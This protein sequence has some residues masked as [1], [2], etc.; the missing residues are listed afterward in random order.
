MRQKWRVEE[1]R[2][3]GPSYPLKERRW[4]RNPG[5]QRNR[6]SKLSGRSAVPRGGNFPQRRRSASSFRVCAARTVSPN[7]AAA[8]GSS[9]TFII[10]GR[11]NFLEAGKKRLA[12]DTARATTSDE[13]KELRREASALKEVWPS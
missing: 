11:R 7:C 5:R 3:S 10:V 13:V 12:S 1:G 4:D 8:R 9:R 2:I 6:R